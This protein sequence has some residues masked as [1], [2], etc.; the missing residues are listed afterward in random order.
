MGLLDGSMDFN[1]RSSP[2]EH[3][4]LLD[5]LA[6]VDQHPDSDDVVLLLAVSYQPQLVFNSGGEELFPALPSSGTNESCFCRNWML[7][8][9]H[10]TRE[11]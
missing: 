4:G 2:L 8:Q 1:S 7:G 9:N 10:S 5:L 11:L 3:G 6:G